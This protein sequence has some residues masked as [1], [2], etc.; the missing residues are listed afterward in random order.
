MRTLVLA[1]ALGLAGMGAAW[2]QGMTA[3]D[4]VNKAGSGGMF[5]VQ[6]SELALQRSQDAK[7]QE[8]AN[9]MIK[10]HTANNEELMAIAKNQSLMAPAELMPPHSDMM[11]AVQAVEGDGFDAAYAQNQVTA[12]ES[13]VD[14]FKTYSEGGDNEALVAYAKKSL[15]VLQQHLEQ[16]QGLGAQ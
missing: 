13:A 9:M 1:A 2:A 8:F 15:P 16:A 5:E 7:V 14:L 3:Q 10:D 4:F 12:H 6:S 11:Q